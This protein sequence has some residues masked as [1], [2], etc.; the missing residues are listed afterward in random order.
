MT[1]SS[2]SGSVETADGGRVSMKVKISK[3]FLVAAILSLIAWI[4]LII[5][6]ASPYWLSSYQYTYS[7]FVRL[8][9]WDFCFNNYRHPPYQYDEKFNG[10]HFIYSSKFQ[11]I[12]DWLQPGW[13]I[14]VQAMM[15]IAL[16]LSVC[17]LCTLAIV[18]MYYLVKYQ[19]TVIAAAAALQGASAVPL[20]LAVVVF[21]VM[22]FDRSWLLFPNYNHLDWAFF[23][24]ILSL[25]MSTLATGLLGLEM[26]A[27]K[28]RRKKFDN[29][30]Y[31]MQP[32]F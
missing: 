30:V 32:R 16:L 2:L 23:V 31:N 24:A 13:F 25:I 3:R 26:V 12:R 17:C 1:M 4:L 18:M 20:F 7:A 15:V 29:L 14:F 19:V 6:F 28:E 22:A 9:L 21:G 11:N 27:A 8:G 5:A 10:C